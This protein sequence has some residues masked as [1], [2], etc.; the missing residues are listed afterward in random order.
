MFT[1]SGWLTLFG[2]AIAA[3]LA[4]T[5]AITE[6]W[7]VAAGLAALALL[8]LLWVRGTAVRVRLHRTVSPLQIY[9]GDSGRIHISAVNAGSSATPVL[10]LHDPVAGT[11]GAQLQL[12]PLGPGGVT[13]FV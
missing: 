4:R 11:R 9:A 13:S 3:A 1:R 5:F 10:E 7:V 8:A 2:A 6:L 12:A